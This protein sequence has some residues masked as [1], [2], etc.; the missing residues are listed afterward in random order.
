MVNQQQN[1]DSVYQIAE[2][3]ASVDSSL[4]I[5]VQWW[6]RKLSILTAEKKKR[7]NTGWKRRVQDVCQL[8][9]IVSNRTF[10][11]KLTFFSSLQGHFKEAMRV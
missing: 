8:A 11:K 4:V 2:K 5:Q 1:R 3:P 6:Q 7:E 10:F 9:G